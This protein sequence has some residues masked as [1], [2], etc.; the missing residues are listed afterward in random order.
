MKFTR[1]KITGFKSFID[2]TILDIK[3]GLTGLVGPNGCGKSNIVEAMKW[4]MGEAGPSK[5]RAG[6]M[7]DLIFA[8]TK[9]RA[10]RNSA[11]VILT[12]ENSENSL[13]SYKNDEE[14]EV[15][16]KIGKD[17]GSTYRINNKE[18][19]QRDVQILFADLAIGS[20]SNSIV[21][22]GQVGKIINSKPQERRKI[23][24]EA[25]GISGIHARKHESE[26]KLKS[27]E[28]NLE[29]LEEIISNDKMRLK[30]LFRQ[31]NQAKKYK[32]IAENIRKTEAIIL[33]QRWKDTLRYIDENKKALQVYID[34]VDAIT[35]NISKTDILQ[36]EIEKDLPSLRLESQSYSSLLNKFK[37]EYDVLNKE[38]ENLIIEQEN[39]KKNIQYMETE[40]LNEQKLF[41]SLNSQYEKLDIEI[42]KISKKDSKTNLDILNKNLQKAKSEEK[43]NLETLK[44]AE[45]KLNYNVSQRENLNNELKKLELQ[46]KEN[47]LYLVNT[48]KEYTLLNNDNKNI[49]QKNLFLKNIDDLKQKLQ[50]KD[51]EEEN[52]CKNI[53]TINIE[54]KKYQDSINEKNTSLQKSYRKLEQFNASKNILTK[55]F[56][57]DDYNIVINFLKYPKGYEK[58]IEACL[59]YG[60]KASLEASS[61]EWRN[62]PQESLFQL[63]ENIDNLSKFTQGVPEVVNIL[64][65]TGI[66]SS[67]SEGDR[68]QH[69]L[70]PGQQLVTSNGGL[71]RWDGYTHNEE[72]E[73]PA[74]QILQNKTNLIEINSKIN[75]TQNEI[76]KYKTDIQKTEIKINA[77]EKV[78]NK[79]NDTIQKINNIKIQLRNDI[80][81]LQINLSKY[82]ENNG[83]K[84]TKIAI[85]ESSINKYE[86]TIKFINKEIDSF[87]KN[88]NSLV[89][90]KILRENIEKFSIKNNDKKNELTN[91]I[92]IYQKELSFLENKEQQL[93]QIRNEKS[94][95]SSQI[96]NITQRINNLKERKVHSQLNVKNMELKPKQIKEKKNNIIDQID[97]TTKQLSASENKLSII[98]NKNKEINN[99]LKKLN[100]ELI[101]QSENKARHEG[102][103]QQAGERQKDEKDIVFEK[104]NITPDNFHKVI[105][106]NE[107][108]P[109]SEQSSLTLEK[110]LLQRERIGPINL[111]AEQDSENL[112]DKLKE[113][114]LERDDLVNAI[115]K[116]RTSIRSINKEAKVRL[117]DAFKEVNKNFKILFT[118]LFGGGEAYLELT[119]SDNPLDS[120]LELMASPPGK[121]LQ[122]MSL[123][124]GGEQAL[125]AMSL[126]FSVFLTKP[127]PICVLDEV[128]APLD[129]SNVDRF[130]D[131]IESISH[132]SKTRFLVVSH[133]RLTMA[134]M[135]RLYGVTMQEPGVSQ[136]V[137]V[138]LKEAE[139]IDNTE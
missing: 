99:S 107:N 74:N 20:R 114:E 35:R 125:T 36:Q 89:N 12:I 137:S 43:F 75:K 117:L 57:S 53:N 122:Q 81:Q 87:K 24:E 95:L 14:I 28:I 139:N 106:L 84:R 111:V 58:A 68:L 61:I 116:L 63:P 124:S 101:I 13:Q 42:D 1:L 131:L 129:E 133:N 80:E 40:I 44:E 93:N 98:E 123:L 138:S 46:L 10:S 62:I 113:I 60:L 3:E 83:E 15:S 11:E 54:I 105:D 22:Q 82:I 41:S 64:K 115:G 112:I 29:K 134:R 132:K 48:K 94:R 136:L 34:N 25:A 47:K 103:L 23:L 127:S 56:E 119:E 32:N 5:L 91:Q 96:A 65:L 27:T 121:K 45:R 128:D 38:E 50:S 100:E 69:K 76:D 39:Q 9:G 33:Y 37:V 16:R 88:L 70:K 92:S 26:L 72:A 85:L 7:N 104:L 31:S 102:L 18:V 30:E 86:Q 71:W 4:N 21:D 51:I 73:T 120:G 19:R 78:K 97:K 130:L 108:L 90:E 2:T 6:E 52:I 17:D 126:I 55:L 77:A 59:G 66:V 8:G 109:N 49:D 118:D 135:H 67:I 110:L 79:N